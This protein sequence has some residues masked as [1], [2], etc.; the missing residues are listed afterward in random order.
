VRKRLE[1]DLGHSVQARV[2]N[3]LTR[4]SSEIMSL[5]RKDPVKWRALLRQKYEIAAEDLG[6]GRSHKKA[7][8][9]VPADARETALAALLA[10][11]LERRPELNPPVH[12]FRRQVLHG[13]LLEPA[14]IPEWVDGQ[15]AKQGEPS[16]RAAYLPVPVLNGGRQA[17][18]DLLFEP[19]SRDTFSAWLRDLA[20]VVEGLPERELQMPQLAAS[21]AI[22]LRYCAPSGSVLSRPIRY[23]GVLA[24]LKE[25]VSGTLGVCKLTGWQEHEGVAF[26]LSGWVPPRPRLSLH[27]Y[28]YTSQLFARGR[29]AIDLDLRV[30]P[31]ELAA[32]YAR[33]RDKYA[34]GA[35]RAVKPKYLNLAIFT[36]G[37]LDEHL[38]WPQRRA[39][40]N[41]TVARQWHY[42]IKKDPQAKRF[43][44][45]SRRAWERL[46]GERWP[47]S[48]TGRRGPVARS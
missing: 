5:V 24:A 29:I 12:E 45:D 8:L 22:E 15:A 9:E 23:D 20:A 14:R 34:Q 36:E 1:E 35:D 21:D 37:L 48:R 38:T 43:A 18:S 2:W 4:M 6:A 25:A 46:S 31:R 39:K 19:L 33:V 28:P 26:V 11:R 44:L 42:P 7:S 41:A 10:A 47:A 27:V 13:Q 40:W 3:H 30:P 17:W 16:M 32:T